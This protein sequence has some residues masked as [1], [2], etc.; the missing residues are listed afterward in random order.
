MEETEHDNFLHFMTMVNPKD[1]W[2]L[3]N[4]FIQS[5]IYPSNTQLSAHLKQLFNSFIHSSLPRTGRKG[6]DTKNIRAHNTF[7]TL[8]LI[9]YDLVSGHLI[10]R[11][12]GKHFR[13]SHENE[14]FA[15]TCT[16]IRCKPIGVLT[17]ENSLVW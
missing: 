2:Q 8:T 4:G 10:Y 13:F 12:F 16:W 5:K 9:W 3:Q 15:Q 14:K 17:H 1:F 11:Y 6:V 7:A